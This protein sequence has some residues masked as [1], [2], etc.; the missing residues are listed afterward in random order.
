[1]EPIIVAQASQIA[2]F[3]NQTEDTFQYGV[4]VYLTSNMAFKAK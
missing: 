1:M 3:K 4:L 2:T